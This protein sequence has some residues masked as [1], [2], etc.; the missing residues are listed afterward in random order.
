M[1]ATLILALLAAALGGCAIVPYGYDDGY[2]HGYYRGHDYRGDRLD[3]DHYYRHDR[4]RHGDDRGRY[5]GGYY[6]RYQD[7]GQ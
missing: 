6:D 2:Y 5:Y 4:W 1:K 7:H 3:H